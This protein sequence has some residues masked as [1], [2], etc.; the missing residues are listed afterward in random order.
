MTLKELT[1]DVRKQITD[2]AVLNMVNP[3][4]AKIENLHF[5]TKDELT[6]VREEAVNNRTTL[7]KAEGDIVDLQ[8]KLEKN[9]DDTELK[10]AQAKILELT[11]FQKQI[12][13]EKKLTLADKVKKYQSNENFEKVKGNLNLLTKTE[14]DAEGK[15]KIVF[16]IDAMDDSAVNTSLGKFI[17]YE[18]IGVLGET[19]APEIDPVTKKPVVPKIGAKGENEPID[20]VKQA[21]EDPEGYAKY[22]EERKKIQFI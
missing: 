6:A 18:G 2:E 13:G 11:Q 15:D 21:K 16:D 3:L 7:R 20:R 12:F 4:L 1:A 8:A 5:S 14:K 10:E 19:K 22:R 17:E 9:G